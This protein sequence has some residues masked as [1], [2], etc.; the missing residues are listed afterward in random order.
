MENAFHKPE[1]DIFQATQHGELLPIENDIMSDPYSTCVPAP[2]LYHTF[3][4][5]PHPHPCTFA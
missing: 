4:P 1:A 2:H 3:Y 5:L